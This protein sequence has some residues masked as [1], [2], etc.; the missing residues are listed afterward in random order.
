MVRYFS[1]WNNKPIF[2]E[3]EAE[4]AVSVNSERYIAMIRNFLTSQLAHFPVNEDTLFQQGGA[5]SHTVRISMD[6]RN[7]LFSGHVISRNGN[8]P[9]LPRPPNLTACDFFV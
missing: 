9:W 2:F 5:T 8:I 6:A 7:D 1:K 4:N 3:N